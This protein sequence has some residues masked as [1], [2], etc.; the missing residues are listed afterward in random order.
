MGRGVINSITKNNKKMPFI[1]EEIIEQVITRFDLGEVQDLESILV[2]VAD[3]QPN[4]VSYFHSNT[5][6]LTDEEAALLLFIVLVISFSFM[7][8]VGE[9]LTMVDAA[10]LEE[11]EE[12]TWTILTESKGKTFTQRID[13]FFENCEQEDLLAFVEDTLA[14]D[15]DSEVT[16]IGREPIFVVCRTILEALHRMTT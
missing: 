14:Y 11:I 9:S 2:E 6:I 3:V 16:N 10:L 12:E 7:E 5:S 8:A 4:I 1:G 15:E 13:P